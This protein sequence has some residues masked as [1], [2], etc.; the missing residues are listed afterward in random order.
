MPADNRWAITVAG[1]EGDTDVVTLNEHAHI[2][3][4]RHDGVRD[5]Y[6]TSVNPDE[7]DVLIGGVVANLDA[8]LEQAGLSD[9]AEVMILP[10]DVSRG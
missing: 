10:K 4:L 2:R 9:R 8:T 6:G 3:Q 7:Y 5:L 1:G